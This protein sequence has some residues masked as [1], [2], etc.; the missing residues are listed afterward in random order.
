MHPPVA[1]RLGYSDQEK[2]PQVNSTAKLRNHQPTAREFEVLQLI[3]DG[4]TS[5]EIAARLG[6]TF[7]TATCHRARLMDKAAVHS[8]ISLFRWALT[9]GFVSFEQEKKCE[10]AAVE[11]SFKAA[12]LKA[13]G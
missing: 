7:K 1:V 10:A 13:T 3:C 11:S 4:C 6:I 8:S 2:P 9:S 12:V 5:K